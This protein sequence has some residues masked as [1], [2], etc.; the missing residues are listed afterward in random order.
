MM[1]RAEELSRAAAEEAAAATGGGADTGSE[2][3]ILQV[4]MN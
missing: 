3:N 2:P 4:F 1:L